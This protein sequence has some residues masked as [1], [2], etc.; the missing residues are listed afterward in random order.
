MA[1]VLAKCTHCGTV[2][3]VEP[4]MDASVCPTCGTAF[5]VEKAIYN[6]QASNEGNGVPFAQPAQMNP[7]KKSK[8]GKIIAIIVA[9]VILIVGG[10]LLYFALSND[11]MLDGRYVSESGLYE[12]EFKD[13][14]TCTWHQDVKGNKVY[15]DGT[16]EKDGDVYVLHM[17]GETYSYNTRFEA[18]PVDDGLIVTGGL[19]NGELF[20]EK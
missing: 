16:Y 6:Y 17:D 9:V 3:Q 20:V 11:D 10:I 13:D 8:T 12:I 14:G 7:A 5:I 2:L 19:V 4:T 1:P 15:F 18:E